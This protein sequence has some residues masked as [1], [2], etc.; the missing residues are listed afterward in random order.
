MNINFSLHSLIFFGHLGAIKHAE[1]TTLTLWS[2]VFANS[3]L[4]TQTGRHI[5][6]H[7]ESCVWPCSKWK[8][9]IRSPSA[10]SSSGPSPEWIIMLFSWLTWGEPQSS[11]TM[12][13]A[14]SRVATHLTF[15]IAIWSV[16]YRETLIGAAWRASL[17]VCVCGHVYSCCGD[18]R[19]L[20]QSHMTLRGLAFLTGT[21]P[22]NVNHKILEWRQM[23][24]ML[25]SKYLNALDMWL[26]PQ[27]TRT[28]RSLP[29]GHHVT[30]DA[31]THTYTGGTIAYCSI[32]IN[33]LLPIWIL[34]IAILN[35]GMTQKRFYRQTGQIHHNILDSAH[36]L[37]V[38]TRL[39]TSISPHWQ[40]ISENANTWG[41]PF[42]AL[43]QVHCVWMSVYWCIRAHRNTH[44]WKCDCACVCA[45]LRIRCVY[46]PSKHAHPFNFIRSVWLLNHF[47]LLP[48]PFL[49]SAP[50]ASFHARFISKTPLSLGNKR[51]K[52]LDSHQFWF[53]Q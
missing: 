8:S 32:Y 41:R 24:T 46:S 26:R 2:N 12:L 16:A 27:M 53:L 17:C 23:E 42:G 45:S 7:L 38:F 30:Y 40:H 52:L 13:S 19:H 37:Q 25:N 20:T 35:K 44:K 21:S 47:P 34:V 15:Y 10:V 51:S 49:S 4:F 6:I 3:R 11:V 36:A 29:G 39:S 28:W 33:V 9:N 31:Y 50:S 22:H 5:S 1:N 48:A 43:A 14:F 18:I